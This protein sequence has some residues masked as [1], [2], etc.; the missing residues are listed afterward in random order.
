[1]T[2]KKYP[3]NVHTQKI[4]TFLKTPKI[5]KFKN[6]HQ[7]MDRAYVC[8]KISEYPPPP[9]PPPPPPV[10]T[11]P[12]LLPCVLE[13]D[14]LT[15]PC[16]VL[17]QPRKTRSDI[18]E[19]FVYWDVKIQ[20]KQIVAWKGSAPLSHWRKIQQ[21]QHAC[22]METDVNKTADGFK[23]VFFHKRDTSWH[24]Q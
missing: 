17:G 2:P 18:T 21:C 11:L 12:A 24:L 3:Q 7:K 4:F 8:M 16:L 23:S 22:P 14:P 1:M 10:Q 13:Q 5:L 19:K 15:N 20:T 6:L 9:P